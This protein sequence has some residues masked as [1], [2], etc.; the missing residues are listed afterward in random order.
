M[1]FSIE[2]YLKRI[3][4][5]PTGKADREQLFEMHLRHAKAIPFENF[6]PYLG[7]AVELSEDAVYEK[8]VEGHRGG[9]CFEMNLLFFTALKALGF[10]AEGRIAR[11]YRADIRDFGPALH[12]VNLVRLDGAT[13]I[14]DVGYGGDNFPEPLL[15]EEGLVQERGLEKYRVSRGEKIAHIVEIARGE[16]WV[17]MLGFGDDFTPDGDFAVGSYYTSTAPESPFRAHIMLSRVTDT[18]RVAFID[19]R[20]T[21]REF[22]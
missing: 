10:D 11:I 4:M 8:I 15:F 9:Y 20:L 22:G 16:E 5:M 2:G 19:N 21:V 17:P 18:G 12:R 13:Y 14:C 3:G 6:N 1:A 7:R